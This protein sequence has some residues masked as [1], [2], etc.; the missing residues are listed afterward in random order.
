[1]SRRKRDPLPFTVTVG[2]REKSLPSY[3]AACA[4]ALDQASRTGTTIYIR[5]Y[6]DI[7]ARAEG[8]EDGSAVLRERAA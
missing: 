5:E 4:F 8:D 6:G 1:M 3:G 7:I 2:D